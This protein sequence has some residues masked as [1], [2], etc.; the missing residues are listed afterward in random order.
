MN[1]H[2]DYLIVGSGVGGSAA[3]YHLARSGKTVLLIEKG[4]VLPTDGSTLDVDKVFRQGA[5]KS[6]E[7]WLDG[8]GKP[9]VPQE[10]YNL[11]GKTKWYGAALLRFAPHEFAADEAHQC[12]A[13]PVDYDEMAPFYGEAERLLG[14]RHFATEPELRAILGRLQNG[15]AGWPAGPLPLGLK[16]EILDHPEEAKHFD[17]FASVKGLKFDAQVGLLDRVRDRPNL[18]VITGSPVA[19]LDFAEGAP[20]RITGVVCE[21]G[22]RYRAGKVLLAAGAL[23]SPRF[24]QTHLER[25][26]L[27]ARLP[28]A[29]Q[30]GRYY[31][32]HLNAAMIGLSPAVKTDLLRK[33]IL[34]LDKRFPHSSVQ[35][36]GWVDGEIVATELPRMV[37]PWVADLVG[38][39]AYGFWL[40]SE[41][42]SHA[43]NRVRARA[44]GHERPQLDYDVR[45]LRPAVTE[46]RKL[47]RAFRAQLFRAGFVTVTKPMPVAATAHACGTMAAGAD[48]RR[49]VVDRHGCVH[50]MENLYVVDGSVLS[51]SGRV[52]PAL[53]IAAWSLRVARLLE[54]GVDRS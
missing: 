5:F 48:P 8:R 28:S 15:G 53:T 14:V 52:N 18:T 29:D 41:D 51:R 2:Y 4:G 45:R 26:G 23:H 6:H 49:S 43:Q 44:D 11:G 7:P 47:L 21:D 36:L 50:G 40:T 39:R 9:L 31:K 17:G 16:P 38:R 1:T 46:H 12:L 34:I 13:W 33:T 35:T 20:E 37:P 30:V 24:L 42:G 54:P 27:A 19:A 3:A 32:C 10:Y 22:T 25:T